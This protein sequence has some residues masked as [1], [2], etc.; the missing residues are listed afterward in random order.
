MKYFLIAFQF[1]TAVPFEIKS[2]LKEED[3]GK[4]LIYFPLVGAFIGSILAL[5]L[6]V[7]N[8]LPQIVSIA[9]ILVIS[10]VLTGG[11]HID[12]FAD[13]CDGFYSGRSKDD[14]LKIMRDSH[15]GTMGVIGIFCVLLLKFTILISIPKEMLWKALIMM[16]VFSRWAQA[17]ACSISD[18]ARESG[19]AEY[20]I[21]YSD[22]RGIA[23]SSLFVLALFFLLTGFKGIILFII[24]FAS[25]FLFIFYV[26]RKIGGMT[27]D[28][29]G[30]T[31]EIAEILVILF[32][33]F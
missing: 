7:L 1:L 14:M 33:L 31:N 2:E 18:Y 32:F 23:I 15:I 19:K 16:A 27:G 30:A 12:G 24:S 8:F 28:T 26:K 20:F 13:T 9:F 5:S 6:F 11:I 10:I 4:S 3:F 21:K 22:K 29:I 25:I 17:L